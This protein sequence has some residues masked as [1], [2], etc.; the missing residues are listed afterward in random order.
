M[1]NFENGFFDEN[2]HVLKYGSENAF[3]R[4]VTV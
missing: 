2:A 4:K 1:H 3:S